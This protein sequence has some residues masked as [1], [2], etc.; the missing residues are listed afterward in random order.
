MRGI[1]QCL[2]AEVRFQPGASDPITIGAT[3][4]SSNRL[5]QRNLAIVESDNPGTA[6]AHVVQHTVTVKPSAMNRKLAAVSERQAYDELVIH[7]NGLPGATKATLYF[8]E[9]NV[10]D[11]LRLANT[12]RQR[13]DLLKKWMRIRSNASSPTSATFRCLSH[14][15]H[16]VRGT[17]DLAHAAHGQ[18]RTS[19][20]CG[21]ATAFRL[22]ARTAHREG[23]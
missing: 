14:A 7:W 20:P 12:L 19:V 8:P 15:K 18:E 5:S 23:E 16:R 13:P 4:G 10:D 21:R 22:G 17:A 3:P 11:I 6:E 1:H 9:W 2:V